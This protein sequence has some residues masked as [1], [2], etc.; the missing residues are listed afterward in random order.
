[1]RTYPWAPVDV[2]GGRVHRQHHNLGGAR[3]FADAPGSLDA[4]QFRHGDVEHG[5]VRLVLLDQAQRGAAIGGV[6]DDLDAVL[7]L[8]HHAQTIADHGVVVGKNHPDRHVT[9]SRKAA[10][11]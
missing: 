7:R 6:A 10:A 4:V 3:Q 9:R 8:E 5:H 2:L 11:L 1:L